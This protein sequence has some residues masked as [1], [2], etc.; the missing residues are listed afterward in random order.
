MSWCSAKDVKG[1]RVAPG[2][3]EEPIAV[4]ATDL[5]QAQFGELPAIYQLLSGITHGM[6]WRL[7]D[8]VTTNDRTAIWAPEP[9]D[10]G[11]SAL[12]ALTAGHRAAAAQAWHRGFD[13]DP[14]LTVMRE[15]FVA[16]NTLPAAFQRAWLARVGARPTINRFLDSAG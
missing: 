14:A 12:A 2:A 1:V 9:V 8:S 5:V 16:A 4:K 11:G 6:P 3:P 10:I 7:G 15:R 13:D